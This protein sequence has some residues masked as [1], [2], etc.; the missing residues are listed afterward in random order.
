MQEFVL[1][2]R[3][4]KK[5]KNA[6]GSEADDEGDDDDV[7]GTEEAPETDRLVAGL[8]DYMGT[9][10]AN[11]KEPPPLP[12][13]QRERLPLN[14]TAMPERPPLP[15]TPPQPPDHPRKRDHKTPPVGWKTAWAFFRIDLT[16]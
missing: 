3:L 10:V 13:K 11:S 16:L 7:D 4:W 1:F 9:L 8:A 12:P 5:T 2:N 14:G 15:S 6:E